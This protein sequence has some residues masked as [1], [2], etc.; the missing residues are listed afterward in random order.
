VAVERAPPDPVARGGRER[1]AASL[2]AGA[3]AAGL[4]RLS[5]MPAGRVAET[6]QIADCSR[7]RPTPVVGQRAA[8]PDAAAHGVAL[9]QRGPGALIRQASIPLR[10]PLKR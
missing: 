5:G 6:A 8:R 10:R 9:G 4:A 1:P 2:N 7:R 3:V